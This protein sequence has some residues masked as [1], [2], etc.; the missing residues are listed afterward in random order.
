M[1]PVST[2]QQVQQDSDKAC[3]LQSSAQGTHAGLFTSAACD[4]SPGCG[5]SMLRIAA[6][7]APGQHPR[8]H[9]AGPTSA[10]VPTL[11]GPACSQI[12]SAHLAD[13]ELPDASSDS[14]AG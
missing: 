1:R 8:L 9:C 10:S 2:A 4:A 3:V 6:A 13:R 14:P 11:P 5:S 7:P 12:G